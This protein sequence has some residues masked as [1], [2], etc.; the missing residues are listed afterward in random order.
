VGG[1]S[2]LALLVF[3]LLSLTGVLTRFP[4]GVDAADSELIQL[5]SERDYPA[6]VERAEQ[7]I[8]SAPFD[9]Q[10]LTFGGFGHFYMG[11]DALEDNEQQFHLERS[12]QLL[13]KA[14][15]L[16]RAPLAAERDYVLGKAYF[17]K[18]DQ[19]MDLA[20]SKME[21]SLAAGYD[22]PDSRSYLALAYAG[23]NAYE[24]SAVWF[25]RAMEDAEERENLSDLNALR[26]RAAESYSA[27]G[28]YQRAETLLRAAIDS[29]DDE[30]LRLMARNRLAE[31]F[32]D[33]ERLNEAESF[34]ESTLDQ[35]PESADA[36][37]YLG[38][39]FHMTD[40]PVEA[41]AAWRTARDLDPN[42]AAALAGLAGNLEN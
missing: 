12:V 8:E 24:E 11:V 18:G 39:V 27:I 26:V 5:W 7:V 15:L 2:G 29:L 25:E 16:E 20:I 23:T 22:A 10:A 31:V 36:H 37:Y 17:H 9:P 3:A 13:R 14:N 35:Y 6:V 1:L 30:F 33:S 28:E 34:I 32:I 40:R 42:H 21:D 19:Y 41:R 38:V 4:F